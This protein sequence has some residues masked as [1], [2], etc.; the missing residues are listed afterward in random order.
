MFSSWTLLVF[1]FLPLSVAYHIV[2]DAN[3]DIRYSVRVWNPESENDP[4]IR[5]DKCFNNT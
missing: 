5:R 3:G 4:N 2:D 1:S